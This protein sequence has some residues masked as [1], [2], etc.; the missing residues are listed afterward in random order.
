MDIGDFRVWNWYT[1]KRLF[2][3]ERFRHPDIIY[4]LRSS[5]NNIDRVSMQRECTCSCKVCMSCFQCTSTIMLV[6]RD[7]FLCSNSIAYV[8]IQTYRISVVL[9]GEERKPLVW[10]HK[11]NTWKQAWQNIYVKYF[12]LSSLLSKHRTLLMLV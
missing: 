11:I 2:R 7:N 8:Y 9:I 4:E 3:H 1:S 12:V 5:G 10:C 6:L